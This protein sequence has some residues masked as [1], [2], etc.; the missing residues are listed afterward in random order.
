M[1]IFRKKSIDSVK[2]SSSN[3]GLAKTLTAFDLIL[4]G[5]GA[6][7][8]TGVFVLTGV[9]AAKYSGPAVMLSYTIAGVTCIF[10]A[11]AY[12]ELASMLPTSG[13]IYTYSFVAFGEVF[14]WIMGGILIIEL[15]LGAATVS[16]GWSGY[17][18]GLLETAGYNIPE[19]LSKIPSQGGIIDI[20]AVS[21]S[22]FVGFI[23]YLGTKDSKK[24]NAILVFIKMAAIIA[25]IIAAAPSFKIE[26]WEDFMPYGFD[27]VLI[28]ASILFFSFSG[29]GALASC[30][31]ECKNPEKDLMIGIIGSLVLAT[32]VYAIM[33]GLVT[34]IAPYHMLNNSEPLA[35]ALRL[36]GSNIGSIIV[37]TG[38]VCGMTTVIMMNIYAQSRIFYVMARD[39]LIPK[40]FSKIHHKY[41]NP[42]ITIIMFSILTAI[43]GGLVDF[44]TLGSLSSMGALIDYIVVITI[45]VLFRFKYPDMKRSFRCPTIFIIAP[46]AIVSCFYLLGKQVI[47]KS[48]ELTDK[49]M[50]LGFWLLTFV[51]LYAIKKIFTKDQI[52]A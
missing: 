42:Y 7:I 5:L 26:N 38:A 50:L 15:C 32:V 12:T 3:S 44:E 16:A 39:G 8:G 41:D 22:L 2:E 17:V 10:V 29:F 46:I 45:V 43:L 36:N 40:M 24:L 34:G 4:F 31:E 48:Y 20:F 33:G 11:L 25:F 52:K 21:I 35:K 9:V 49:G 37:A 6:I 27:D 19:A 28:G 23:L 14:A 51:V 30:A 1:S 18:R 13:S 47:G